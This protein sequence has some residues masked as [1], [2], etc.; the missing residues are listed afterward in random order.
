MKSF[1]IYLGVAVAVIL[2]I[3]AVTRPFPIT[4]GAQSGPDH[5]NQQNFQAGFTVGTDT[6]SALT[7]SSCAT[8]TTWDPSSIAM[9][10]T[11]TQAIALQGAT[12]GDICVANISTT[13]ASGVVNVSCSITASAASASAYGTSTVLVRNTGIAVDFPTTTLRTCYFGY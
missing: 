2:A 13:T 4:P 6:Y 12:V 10:G 3:V 5:Y 11:T 7:D 1:L 9:N 8:L